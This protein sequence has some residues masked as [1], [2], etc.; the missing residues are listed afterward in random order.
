MEFIE[1][2]SPLGKVIPENYSI[3][4]GIHLLQTIFQAE[5]SDEPYEN[6]PPIAS[7]FIMNFIG[8]DYHIRLLRV[9][10]NSCFIIKEAIL[11][12]FLILIDIPNIIDK[13]APDL[14]S[15]DINL[16]LDPE[17]DFVHI[18]KEME[19]GKNKDIAAYLRIILKLILFSVNSQTL[20]SD[21]ATQL[22]DIDLYNRLDDMEVFQN[23]DD[24]ESLVFLE[25]FKK[26][27]A[28]FL[29]ININSF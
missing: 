7:S 29:N 27:L 24:P 16:T 26:K 28:E 6:K 13:I 18:F 5:L 23:N 21:L 11:H 9:A 17:F 12:L 22:V 15:V 14:I 19:D 3:K 10:H 1:L 20:Y 2:D 8:K 25:Q 4:T